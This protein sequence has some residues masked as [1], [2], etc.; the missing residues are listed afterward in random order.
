MNVFPALPLLPRLALS[1]SLFLASSIFRLLV[2]D[3]RTDGCWRAI[4]GKLNGSNFVIYI[5]VYKYR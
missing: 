1:F 5:D 2:H 3:G 4:R